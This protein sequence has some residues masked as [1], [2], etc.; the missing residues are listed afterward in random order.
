MST[1]L[2]FLTTFWRFEREFSRNWVVNAE[3]L[4]A[5]MDDR[6]TS[7]YRRCADAIVPV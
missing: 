1:A 3:P 5:D 6:L 7:E 2:L 4:T